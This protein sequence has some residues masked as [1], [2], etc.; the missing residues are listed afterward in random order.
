MLI[1]E[2]GLQQNDHKTWDDAARAVHVRLGSIRPADYNGCVT[3]PSDR[4]SPLVPRT[5][6]DLDPDHPLFGMRVCFTGALSRYTRHEA[7][8]AVVDAGG[9]FSDSVTKKTN[10]LVVGTQDMARLNG[11][12]QSSK[13][14]RAVELAAARHPIEVIEEGEFYRLLA[15]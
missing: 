12:D 10:L 5:I 9:E 7:A 6:D 8:H 13:L 3:S 11:Q 1:A 14:R 4:K 15:H 2:H